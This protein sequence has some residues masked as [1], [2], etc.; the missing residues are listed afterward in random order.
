MAYAYY[1]GRYA[2]TRK[3]RTGVDRRMEEAAML[4]CCGICAYCT[5][6]CLCEHPGR[7]DLAQ[8]SA[9]GADNGVTFAEQ[10]TLRRVCTHPGVV[11][12]QASYPDILSPVPL[13]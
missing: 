8:G 3:W 2:S 7:P 5:V 4:I 13:N 11:E 12:D 1:M 9:A 6:G 10:I